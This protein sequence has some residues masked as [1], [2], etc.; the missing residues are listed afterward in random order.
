LALAEATQPPIATFTGHSLH[1]VE[2]ILGAVF[3]APPEPCF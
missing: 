1:G 2:A 3:T